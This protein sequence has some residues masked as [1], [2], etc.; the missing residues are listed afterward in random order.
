MTLLDKATCFRYH[1]IEHLTKHGK[2]LPSKPAENRTRSTCTTIVFPRIVTTFQTVFALCLVTAIQVELQL[3]LKPAIPSTIQT[4]PQATLHI[5]Q[6]VG[7]EG[8]LVNVTDSIK[9]QSMAAAVKS[10]CNNV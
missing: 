5:T 8:K 3:V 4:L 1:S 2:A 6:R 9:S 10:G 7:G